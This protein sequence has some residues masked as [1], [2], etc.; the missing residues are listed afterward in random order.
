MQKLTLVLLM[1]AATFSLESHHPE[2]LGPE[3]QM[4]SLTDFNN[5]KGYFAYKAV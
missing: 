4:Q 2:T 5:D 3:R 1:V